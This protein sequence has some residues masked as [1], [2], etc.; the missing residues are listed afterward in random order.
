[1]FESAVFTNLVKVMDASGTQSRDI[2]TSS[3]HRLR[4]RGIV[5]FF[6]VTRFGPPGASLKLNN[7]DTRSMWVGSLG[8]A[9]ARSTQGDIHAQ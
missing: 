6:H 7:K 8:D 9:F 4:G 1:M 3:F 5:C 2:M